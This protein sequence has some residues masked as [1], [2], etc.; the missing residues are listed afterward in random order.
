MMHGDGWTGMGLW[1]WGGILMM[2]LFWI[3][4]VVLLIW[5][6]RGWRE[7]REPATPAGQTG[8]TAVGILRERFARGE[9]EAEEFE[10]ARRTLEAG[11]R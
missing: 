5:A 1:G 9:I 11:Q 8:D 3:S 4:F 2:A 7:R 6:T 10:R